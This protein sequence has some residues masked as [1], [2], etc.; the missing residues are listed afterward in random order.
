[1]DSRE[2]ATVIS[3]A[4]NDIA[5]SSGSVSNLD[6]VSAAWAKMDGYHNSLMTSVHVSGAF[7]DNPIDLSPPALNSL[8]F[9]NN[10]SANHETEPFSTLRSSELQHYSTPAVQTQGFSNTSR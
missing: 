2:A 10:L 1:M 8:E 6:N 9:K 7:R 3:S 4:G 5:P